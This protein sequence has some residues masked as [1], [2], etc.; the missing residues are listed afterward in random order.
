MTGRRT[1][2]RLYNYHKICVTGIKTLEK[3]N[4][5]TTPARINLIQDLS[6]LGVLILSNGEDPQLD[7]TYFNKRFYLLLH[8]K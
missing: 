2:K 3:K 4:Y 8:K 5:K 1:D 6:R 7:V